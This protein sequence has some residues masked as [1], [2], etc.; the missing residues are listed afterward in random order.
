MSK[1]YRSAG[2]EFLKNNS[3]LKTT[4]KLTAIPPQKSQETSKR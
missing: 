4:L 1:K 2:L 3:V